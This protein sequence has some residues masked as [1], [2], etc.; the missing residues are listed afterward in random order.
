MVNIKVTWVWLILRSCHCGH[1]GV[2]THYA[3]LMN[4]EENGEVGPVPIIH[5]ITLHNLAIYT[6]VHVC[7]CTCTVVAVSGIV[8]SRMKSATKINHKIN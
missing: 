2:V 8:T 3:G 1:M 7:T 6:H 4:L 5:V